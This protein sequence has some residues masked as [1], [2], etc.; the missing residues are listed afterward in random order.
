MLFPPALLCT[1]V[2]SHRGDPRP[3]PAVPN[4]GGIPVWPLLDRVRGIVSQWIHRTLG[5]RGSSHGNGNVSDVMHAKRTHGGLGVPDATNIYI[6]CM[7]STWLA[8]AHSH[9][10][11]VRVA[12]MSRISAQ[13]DTAIAVSLSRS[14]TEQH[15]A[16]LNRLFSIF[17]MGI[18]IHKGYAPLLTWCRTT[19]APAR[20]ESASPE[21]AWQEQIA[22]HLASLPGRHIY[23]PQHFRAVAMIC[24]CDHNSSCPPLC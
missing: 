24:G 5:L 3:S 12:Y 13:A 17:C 6:E 10:P 9:V 16:S 11:A 15:T 14:I 8:G 22:T 1:D 7:T 19:P 2:R 23:P 21:A 18:R 20:R 4:P